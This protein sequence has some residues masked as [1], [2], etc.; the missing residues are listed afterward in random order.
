VRR[1][2]SIKAGI[3]VSGGL[4]L[5][6]SLPEATVF[7]FAPYARQPMLMINGRYDYF[8]PIDSTQL[9]FFRALGAP[10]KDKRHVVAEAG[11]LPPN[12]LVMK[13]ILDWLDRYLGPVR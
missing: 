9:P 2:P 11:H 3:L 12:D 7:N 10:S 8:F 13:E 6:Q 1:S 4:L 5:Q